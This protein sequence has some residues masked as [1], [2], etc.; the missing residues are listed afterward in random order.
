MKHFSRGSIVAGK[1]ICIQ[2]IGIG[3]QFARIEKVKL[4]Y[5]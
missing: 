1:L 3:V 5:V 2:V 4:T